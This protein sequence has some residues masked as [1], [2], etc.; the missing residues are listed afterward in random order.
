MA[1]T[2]T[3]LVMYGSYFIFS[4]GSELLKDI[5]QATALTTKTEHMVRFWSETSVESRKPVD[6][7]L[8]DTTNFMGQRETLSDSA[9]LANLAT[10]ISKLHAMHHQGV[11]IP[12]NLLNMLD[13]CLVANEAWNIN[14]SVFI[15]YLLGCGI[16]ILL[17]IY[18]MLHG[19]YF[20]YHRLQ[21]YVD[22]QIASQFAQNE[23][24]TKADS[25]SND[26]SSDTK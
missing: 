9:P 5:M 16:I 8:A 10:N 20:W 24:T 21:K 17:G 19:Y 15:Q 23:T 18:L 11:P 2:G 4:K 1:I 25:K 26:K 12:Q 22:L 6:S 7:L 13:S 3:L 14:L